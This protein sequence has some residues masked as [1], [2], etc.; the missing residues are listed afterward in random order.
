M[1]SKV[2]KSSCCEYRQWELFYAANYFKS[3]LLL[4]EWHFNKVRA[5]SLALSSASLAAM[6][7]SI[8]ASEK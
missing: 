3:S 7:S 2:K 4:A 1:F 8:S 5:S 6:T